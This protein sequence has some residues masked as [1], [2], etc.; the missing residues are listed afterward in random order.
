[1]SRYKIADI[2]VQMEQNYP[3]TAPWYQD[4][5]TDEPADFPKTLRCNKK[6][7]DY[8]VTKGEGIDEA[9]AENIL[10]CNLFNRLL[11]RFDGSFIHSSALMCNDKVYLISADSGV[12]KSTLTRRWCRLY[13]E[14]TL[15]INDDKPSFRII[16]DKCII[17]GT[18]FAGGTDIQ[19]NK[20]GELGAI[21]FLERASENK[22]VRL[23]VTQAMPLLFQQTPRHLSA[24]ET[25]RLLELY[26]VILENYPMYKLYCTDSDDAVTAVLDII[27]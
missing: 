15:V 22:L 25:N 16:D 9:I 7:I 18:P 13:P 19:C 11:I 21:V 1:M 23:N 2:V 17:Y 8:L 6:D 10:L 20:K 12:G 4:Y 5:L 3:E 27:K 14:N 24:S 26:G